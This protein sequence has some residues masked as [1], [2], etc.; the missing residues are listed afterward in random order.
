MEGL[1]VSFVLLL[2]SWTDLSR[3][4]MTTAA[5]KPV[6]CTGAVYQNDRYCLK[7]ETETKSWDEADQAC[8]EQGGHLPV[9]ADQETQDA[10][11]NITIEM[12]WEKSWIGGKYKYIIEWVSEVNQ[13]RPWPYTNWLNGEPNYPDIAGCLTL[14]AH[15][16]NYIWKKNP[17]TFSRNYICEKDSTKNNCTVS[18]DDNYIQYGG[19][20][21][22]VSDLQ[23]YSQRKKWED[24][25]TACNTS[26]GHLVN[27]LSKTDE[28][29]IENML[30][31]Y[32]HWLG[33]REYWIGGRYKRQWVWTTGEFVQGKNKTTFWGPGEPNNLNIELCMEVS[34]LHWN[35]IYCW[36]S[37]NYICQ[38]DLPQ[39][40]TTSTTIPADTTDRVFDDTTPTSSLTHVSLS[41]RNTS[42]MKDAL[43]DTLSDT[44]NENSTAITIILAVLAAI[45]FL[46]IV[47]MLATFFTHRKRTNPKENPG[48]NCEL[49]V[50]Q[51]QYTDESENQMYDYA[52]TDFSNLTT[53]SH[54]KVVD[55]YDQGKAAHD[56]HIFVDKLYAKPMKSNKSNPQQ[57]IH[58]NEPNIQKGMDNTNE[59]DT[60]MI[61]NIIY[62]GS[63]LSGHSNN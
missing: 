38:F 56:T 41:H 44:P 52:T 39:L 10:I 34:P 61:E 20:C 28:D 26:G 60:I 5:Y 3:S 14:G 27:I 42:A 29:V 11:V 48:G 31:Y 7:P 8:R 37:Y 1:E 46:I 32:E 53:E 16:D 15:E 55:K 49:A 19:R 9:I 57:S 51:N 59:D 2:I 21:F 35:N 43:S 62:D 12:Q 63:S 40:A 18:N 6:N 24:A 54:N 22:Y 13:L 58:E 30:K 36:S 17:C 33:D 4:Q 23:Y 47:S 45:E 25:D 50:H